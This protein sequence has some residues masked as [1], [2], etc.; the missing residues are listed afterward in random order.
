M[1]AQKGGSGKKKK[2]NVHRKRNRTFSPF[3]FRSQLNV[4]VVFHGD[5]AAWQGFTGCQAVRLSGH[6]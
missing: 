4:A 3:F 2:K 6:G 5:Y 1:K